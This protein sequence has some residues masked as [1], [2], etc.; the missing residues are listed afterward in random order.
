MAV[1]LFNIDNFKRVN[2][3]YGHVAGDAVLAEIGDL[4]TAQVRET[5]LAGRY[6]GEEFLVIFPQA[7]AVQ[8][9]AISE[10]I[11]AAVE[12]HVF[13][14]DIRITISAGVAV[15]R[16]GAHTDLVSVAD[17]RLYAAKWAGK[18]RVVAE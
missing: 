3:T 4:F 10:R 2:D 14:G 6:G 5:D 1:G 17:G 7:T 12:A 8:A 13:P 16:G 11:R 15:A 9:A 18:N